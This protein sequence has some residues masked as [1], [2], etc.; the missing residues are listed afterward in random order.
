MRLYRH[1]LEK[2][3]VKEYL[4]FILFFILAGIITAIEE[5][6]ISPIL[7]NISLSLL[8]ILLYAI[9]Q[10]IKARRSELAFQKLT[11]EE[12]ATRLEDN[13]KQAELDRNEQNAQKELQE[14]YD[15]F[16]KKP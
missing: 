8:I 5:K 15:K 7:I 11:P 14:Y 3:K 9:Y 10:G 13:L 2:L 6:S 12:K 4:W 1:I 16:F